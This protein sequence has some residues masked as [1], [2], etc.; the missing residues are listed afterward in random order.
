MMSWKL[1]LSSLPLVAVYEKSEPCSVAHHSEREEL[2]PGCAGYKETEAAWRCIRSHGLAGGKIGFCFDSDLLWSLSQL[3][4]FP[5]FL[6]CLRET[7]W[8]GLLSLDTFS[9]V[10]WVRFFWNCAVT[11]PLVFWL[12]YSIGM[13]IVGSYVGVGGWP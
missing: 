9:K 10:Y 11:F 8:G 2:F 13:Y 3:L 7:G 4:Y 12:L 6:F 1:Q 5:K